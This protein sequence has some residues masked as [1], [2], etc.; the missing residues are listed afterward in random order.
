MALDHNSL[1]YKAFLE[2]V[3]TGQLE[4]VDRHLAVHLEF[5]D[6]ADGNG[7]KPLYWAAQSGHNSIVELL[8]ERGSTVLDSPANNGLTPL[9]LAAWNGRDS[10]VRL[11]L[12]RG[13]T[14]RDSHDSIGMTPLHWAVYDGLDS[15]IEFLLQCG[16]TSLDSTNNKGWTPLY[17][18]ARQ[19]HDSTVKILK[20]VGGTTLSVEQL[21]PEQIEK[22]QAP[23]PEKEILE[24]RN[25]I[26]FRRSLSWLSLLLL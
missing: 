2:A 12:Q 7:S 6:L 1:E 25:R 13:S 9:H 11:L 16:S 10:T 23:I 8:L 26:Y 19:R 17:L 24:I 3:K 5:L 4:E 15:M 14:S 20:S 18:A 21:N 22:L